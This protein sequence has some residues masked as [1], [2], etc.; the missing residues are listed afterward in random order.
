MATF[1]S[2]VTQP[3]A[4]EPRMVRPGE[5]TSTHKTTHS[6]W[7]EIDG[8]PRKDS[9]DVGCYDWMEEVCARLR[10]PTWR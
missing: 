10:E 2:S 3:A 1:H 7:R 9:G 6:L 8:G 4:E 5:G